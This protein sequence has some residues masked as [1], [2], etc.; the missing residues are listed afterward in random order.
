MGRD[1]S[2][3][4]LHVSHRIDPNVEQQLEDLKQKLNEVG[5]R[6][7]HVDV[8]VCIFVHLHATLHTEENMLDVN[9]SGGGYSQKN[10]WGCA[11][12]FTNP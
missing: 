2:R 7:I 8:I 5:Y 6:G 12:R 1:K 11:A 4:H 9:D 10:W 3:A